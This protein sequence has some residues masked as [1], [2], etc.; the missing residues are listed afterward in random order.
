MLHQ[1][2]RRVARLERQLPR[3]HLI[4]DNPQRI[5]IGAAIHLALS[6]RLLRT[7]I[8]WRAY[9][10]AG[11]RQLLVP[12]GRPRNAEVGDHHAPRRAIQQDIVGLDIAVHHARAVCVLQCARH[13]AQYAPHDI[14]RWARLLV[15]PFGQRLSLD[16]PHRNPDEAIGLVHG[17]NR[18]DVRMR[19]LRGHLGLA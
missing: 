18:H 14:E 6:H 7:H 12:F 11:R 5:Q 1:H 8:R 2:R 16:E 10:N 3:Q 13:V 4:A 19:Q 9:G 17:V 15:E